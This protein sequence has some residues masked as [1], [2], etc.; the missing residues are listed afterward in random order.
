MAN[1]DPGELVRR[2]VAVW[3]EPD[4]GRR[5]QAIRELWAA[6][7][8]HILQPP[9]EV[10]EAA[11]GL[12]FPATTLQA[13]GHDALEA[14]VTRA[15]EEFVAPGGYTFQP[16]DNAALLGDVVK[17]NWEMLPVGGG[18]AAAA[19]LEVLVLDADGRIKADHQFIEA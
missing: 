9:R 6:D 5:R 10:R 18:P 14:R 2:Y 12:G 15:Y 3:H 19:G 13:H 1:V 8:A 4:A 11:A 16:R 7:G 17:F